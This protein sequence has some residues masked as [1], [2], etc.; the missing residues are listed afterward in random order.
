MRSAAYLRYA[1][2]HPCQRRFELPHIVGSAVADQPLPDRLQRGTADLT[3]PYRPISLDQKRL[4]RAEQQPRGIIGARPRFRIGSADDFSELL[5]DERGDGNVL[6]AFD[7][8][9]ELP[10]QQRL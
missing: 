1:C 5:E 10:H 3:W 9:L 7:G 6:A 2:G 8:A 4:Q